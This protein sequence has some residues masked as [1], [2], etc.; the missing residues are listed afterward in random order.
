VP[1]SPA[2][3]SVR[4]ALI[5]DDR[6]PPVADGEGGGQVAGDEP[7]GRSRT[8]RIALVGACVLAFALGFA[9]MTALTRGSDGAP[10]SN[11]KPTQPAPATSAPAA[12]TPSTAKAPSSA[13]APPS[14]ALVGAVG[15][16]QAPA[17]LSSP[18]PTQQTG[19][20]GSPTPSTT[21]SVPSTTTPTT[22]TT[23]ST[24]TP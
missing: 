23:P 3:A 20:A 10:R 4:E 12:P 13:P 11:T 7:G 17:P 22:T 6:T 19:N 5:P 15:N 8:A 1:V 16:D 21:V 9:G 14:S 24:T 2:T 18:P